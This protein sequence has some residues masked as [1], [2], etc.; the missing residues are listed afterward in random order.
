MNESRCC[1]VTE[2]F[3]GGAF[4]PPQVKIS[5]HFHENKHTQSRI[6]TQKCIY[7]VKPACKGATVDF[8]H[9]T[10]CFQSDFFHF[11]VIPV[12]HRDETEWLKQGSSL[13]SVSPP[14]VMSGS[15]TQLIW[16]RAE[17]PNLE[18]KQLLRPV[19]AGFTTLDAAQMIYKRQFA[20]FP[21]RT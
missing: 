20:A 6:I 8:C 9:Y 2:S 19:G 10:I 4:L 11:K 5:V 15:R 12:C 3:R 1:Q 14:P 16:A 18:R 7:Q 21:E 13:K 17:K